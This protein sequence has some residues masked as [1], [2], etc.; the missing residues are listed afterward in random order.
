MAGKT[1]LLY[2]TVHEFDV[3]RSS[4]TFQVMINIFLIYFKNALKSII[5][6]KIYLISI[7]LLFVA[8]FLQP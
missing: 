1:G 4:K 3:F 6:S 2:G 8:L 5:I 7:Y